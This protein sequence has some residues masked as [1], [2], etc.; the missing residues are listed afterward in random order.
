[1]LLVLFGTPSIKAQTASVPS[2]QVV[3]SPANN[4][5][6]VNPDTHLEI[7]FPT[8]PH[9]GTKGKIRIYDLKDNRLVDQLDMSIPAGPDENTTVRTATKPPYLQVPYPYISEKFTNANTKPGTPSA[10][11]TP[12]PDNF[13]LT[14]IG[15]F[16]DGFHFFPII[17][18]NNTATIYPHNNLLEYNKSYY[19]QVDPEV[20]TQNDPGFIGITGKTTWVFSTKKV[21][22]PA[23]KNELIVSTDGTGDFNTI[24]GAL[25]FIPDNN[26]LPV[27][28]IVKNGIYEEIVYFRNKTNISIVGED[29]DKVIIKYANKETFNPHPANLSTNEAEGTFP[30]RRAAFTV[31]HSNKIHLVNLT[32]RTTSFG[33]AEGLLLNGSENI[34]YNVLIGG[35][36][37]ALQTNGSAYY[38]GCRIEGA[39]DVIL[40]RGPTFLKDCEITSAGGAYMWIRN[41]AANHG[42]VFLDCTFKTAEGRETELARAPTNG[43]KGYPDCEA[44]LLNCKLA[45]VSAIG[46]GSIGGDVSNV[47]YWEYNS[48]HLNDAK[49]VDVSKRLPAS[50]QLT[51]EKDAAIIANY[52]K[53][54]YILK[55][56]TPAMAPIILSQPESVIVKKGQAL[57][58]N[59][60][61][62]AIPEANYQWFK[63]N[64]VISRAINPTLNID[65]A[66]A[67]DN[68]NYH[69]LIKNQSGSV[70][71]QAVK[72]TVN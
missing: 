45:G 19:V 67:N 58:F 69:V 70:T 28:I 64:R 44:V 33:Q 30:S 53:P 56:W 47:H 22:P 34:C 18:H 59:V 11:A 62:A 38:A 40:G 14:I 52:S 57:S 43:G 36:G 48:T 66:S 29:R 16:T 4:A 42:N 72:L 5:R 37:D 27:T 17:I 2:K 54:A 71:S 31:D 41:T 61:V 15:G 9:P 21:P 12:T 10:G 49:P 32:I 20:L 51:M 46:W 25:D 50:R 39:G 7:T 23:N 55:G 24:Q 63:D 13:Q 1:M 3:L 6:N 35:S 60:K 68:G 8:V 26:T 65:K